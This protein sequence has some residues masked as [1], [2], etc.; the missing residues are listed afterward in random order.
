MVLHAGRATLGPLGVL[1]VVSVRLSGMPTSSSSRLPGS[2]GAPGSTVVVGPWLGSS[3][4]SLAV[5]G[6]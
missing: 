4:A 5:G 3:R 2:S 1:V 6:P